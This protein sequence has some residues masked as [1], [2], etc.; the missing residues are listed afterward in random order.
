MSGVYQINPS[1][2]AGVRYG[3]IDANLLDE[4]GDHG[5][6]MDTRIKETEAMIAWHPSH[7]STVRVQYTHQDVTGMD[8]N[9]DHVIAVQYIMALGSHGAHQF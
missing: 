1:W 2:S 9:D 7:F 6:F 4:D 8:V 5:L 3:Q